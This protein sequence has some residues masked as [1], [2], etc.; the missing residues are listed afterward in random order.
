MVPLGSEKAFASAA[1]RV[2]VNV[3]TGAAASIVIVV[4]CGAAALPYLS[5]PTTV[6]MWLPF[7]SVEG[8]LS[9]DVHV[10]APPRSMAHVNVA[11]SLAENVN[12]SEAQAVARV[13]NVTTGGVASTVKL[14][15]AAAPVFPAP[16]TPCT[17]ALCV[18]PVANM[19]ALIPDVPVPQL[20]NAPP[21]TAHSKR[22][23]DSCAVNM[24]WTDLPVVA[25]IA[26]AVIITVGPVV[27]MVQRTVGGVAS[28][29]PV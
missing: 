8:K 16:S 26:G 15:I 10:A 3:T 23:S 2:P 20:A 9:G 5:V 19:R 12:G 17:A 6:T 22:A 25:P 29:T 1:G 18:P 13:P 21:S 28:L 14:T 11:V 24:S 27:S 4:I 7:V